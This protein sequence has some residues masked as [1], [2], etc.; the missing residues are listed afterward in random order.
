MHKLRFLLLP[1]DHDHAVNV[2]GDHDGND[3]GDS[4]NTH[5][6]GKGMS[7]IHSQQSQRMNA[8]NDCNHFNRC[9]HRIE[10]I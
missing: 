8:T 1:I 4:V 2:G 10:R 6:N 9:N 7:S 5:L 3:N